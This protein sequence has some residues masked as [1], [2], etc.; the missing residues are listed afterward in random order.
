MKDL[1]IVKIKDFVKD[2]YKDDTLTESTVIEE[3]DDY[4]DTEYKLKLVD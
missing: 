4:G 2:I 1:G 3:E